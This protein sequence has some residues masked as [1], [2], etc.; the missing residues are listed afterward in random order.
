MKRVN[1]KTIA[2][3]LKLSVA[4]VSKCFSN[5]SEISDFT[6][7]RVMEEAAKLGYRPP[8]SRK[9]MTDAK[10]RHRLFAYI[11]PTLQLEANHVLNGAGEAAR[12][13]NCSLTVHHIPPESA[14]SSIQEVPLPY[15]LE[16]GELD[17][18]V[19]SY[20]LGHDLVKDFAERL[21]CVY[22]GELLLGVN[23]DSVCNENN[24]AL[25]E[26]TGELIKA[27]HREIGFFGNYPQY[28]WARN[29]L[30]A[31]MT[32]LSGYDCPVEFDRILSFK[33]NETVEQ[34]TQR[35]IPLIK[36]GVTAWTCCRDET[37]YQFMIE[38]SK[39]GI[40]V[41]QDV[42]LTG[43]DDIVPFY[44]LPRLTTVKVSL[45]DFGRTAIRRLNYRLNHPDEPNT[46]LTLRPT[47]IIGE[48]VTPPSE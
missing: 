6:R 3:S 20:G 33:E 48:T 45:Y 10:N 22:T 14:H 44:G 4:T 31:W 34:L 32:A 42:S 2:E 8:A 38:L 40:R 36:N 29:R 1:Q 47:L 41:P 15:E 18:A 46:N 39:A 21:P 16:R 28:T 25:Q 11:T 27:G 17:G 35:A 26:L 7:S 19:L 37:A 9:Q 24:L 30:A 23:A 5:S 43:F 12:G 13:L